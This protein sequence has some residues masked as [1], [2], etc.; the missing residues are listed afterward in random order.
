M[1]DL[2]P[3]EERMARPKPNYE[4]QKIQTRVVAKRFTFIGRGLL[5][6]MKAELMSLLKTN[7]D[8][9]T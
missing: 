2:D 5:E 8:L 4:L 9:F 7:L 6:A 3:I 1:R